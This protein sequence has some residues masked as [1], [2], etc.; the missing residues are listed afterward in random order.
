MAPATLRHTRQSGLPGPGTWVD[1]ITIWQSLQSGTSCRGDTVCP[2]CS[3]SVPR[4]GLALVLVDTVN[5]TFDLPYHSPCSKDAVDVDSFLQEHQA[6][7]IVVRSIKHA[8]K[9]VAGHNACLQWLVILFEKTI[10]LTFNKYPALQ[11]SPVL[12]RFVLTGLH[13]RV[14]GQ[15]AARA[16]QPRQGETVLVS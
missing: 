3:E 7:G 13:P 16:P 9:R 1:G 6:G 8:L 11:T 10:T 12:P 4:R 2:A 14:P 15:R 5:G